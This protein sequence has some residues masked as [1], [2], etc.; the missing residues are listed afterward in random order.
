MQGQI[1]RK[2]SMLELQFLFLIYCLYIIYVHYNISDGQG[3][4]KFTRM[5][6]SEWTDGP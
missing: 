1:I 5:F 6:T 2:V 4:T 3:A